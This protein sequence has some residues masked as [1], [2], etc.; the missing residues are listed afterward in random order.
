MT[1]YATPFKGLR[2]VTLDHRDK[3]KKNKG[4]QDALKSIR[5]GKLCST[6]NTYAREMIKSADIVLLAYNS[7]G[8]VRGVV[9]VDEFEYQLYVSIICNDME[10]ENRGR[11]YAP[12]KGLLDLLKKIA[13]RRRKNVKLDSVKTAVNY[14]KRFGFKQ[15]PSSNRKTALIW[16]WRPSYSRPRRFEYESV[17]S[18]NNSNNNRSGATVKFSPRKTQAMKNVIKS[19]VKSV[20]SNIAVKKNTLNR[21]PTQRGRN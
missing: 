14:Y 4:I 21:V 19:A 11:G 1:R 3:Y 15:D 13:V 12:G 18:N 20:K 17:N 10:K 2:I 5:N 16:S 8:E 7:A 9:G 6:L